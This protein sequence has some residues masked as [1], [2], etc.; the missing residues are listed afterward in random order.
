MNPSFSDYWNYG[1]I[2]AEFIGVFILVLGG[3]A[4]I[5]L[6]I[7]KF[8]DKPH[9]FTII[10]TLITFCS[11][12]F[13]FLLTNIF[14]SQVKSV[15]INPINL[16]TN[17]L[18]YAILF[19]QWDHI[20]IALFY[21]L[22]E[23]LASIIAS[24]VYFL[25]T[26]KINHIS[27]VRSNKSKFYWKHFLIKE[28]VFLGSLIIIINFIQIFLGKMLHTHVMINALITVTLLSFL[29]FLTAKQGFFTTGLPLLIGTM[30]L[31]IWLG[32]FNLTK[33]KTTTISLSF[34][35]I[36]NIAFTSILTLIIKALK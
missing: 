14:N 8:K 26:H 25:I 21:L 31:N 30:F 9:F 23:F 19:N 3:L 2:L 20:F 24:L 1:N 10:Y 13:G 5:S 15:F 4:T 11:V 18:Y 7:S 33:L 34:S 16:I 36:F 28:I 17:Y 22:I 32:E 29:L 27:L 6:S 12:L 35:I